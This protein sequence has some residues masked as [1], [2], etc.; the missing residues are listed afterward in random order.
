MLFALILS[1]LALQDRPVIESIRSITGPVARSGCWFPLKV[2]VSSASAFEG[3][4][5]ASAD[6]GFEVTRPVR[7]AAGGSI[8]LLLPVVV[9]NSTAKVEVRLRRAGAEL[10][11]RLLPAQIEM[12]GGGR[13]VLLDKDHPEADTLRSQEYELPDETP[14]RFVVS[15]PADWSEAAE[16]GALESVDAVVVREEVALDLSMTLWRTLGGAIVTQPRR[17]LGNHLAKPGVFFG[18]V[19]NRIAGLV[20]KDPWIRT[21]RDAAILF[22]VVYAFGIFVVA[23]ATWRRNGSPA[24]LVG[25]VAGVS[26]AFAAAYGAFFPKGDLSIVAWQA[27]VDAPEGGAAVT[28]AEV[29]AGRPEP[30]E[31][32]FGRL[33]KPVSPTV[34]EAAGRLLELR[35]GEGGSCA[36]RTTG[37]GGPLRF[38]WAERAPRVPAGPT[39]PLNTDVSEYFKRVAQKGKQARIIDQ[40]LETGVPLAVK[41]ESLVEARPVMVLRIDVLR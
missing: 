23:F 11:R 1:L 8:D 16:L 34:A 4:I 39:A 13:L 3:Q 7:L 38:V 36:A 41:A 15:D 19:D 10:E 25:G 31:I 32:V 30:R 18:A 29:R 21:K 24:T 40:P 35:L 37:V 22:F 28:V 26:L 20:W 17:D 14:V 12:L 27:I 33:V 6:A 9:L 2:R 5:A